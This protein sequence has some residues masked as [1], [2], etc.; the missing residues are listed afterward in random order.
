R[1][2]RRASCLSDHGSS[3]SSATPGSTS[4]KRVVHLRL[5]KRHQVVRPWHGRKA[6]LVGNLGNCRRDVCRDVTDPGQRWIE[7]TLFDVIGVDE[8]G[9]RMRGGHE[10]LVGYES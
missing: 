10:H 9:Q 6:A 8:I 1:R 7:A 5:N 2:R 4:I 3:I